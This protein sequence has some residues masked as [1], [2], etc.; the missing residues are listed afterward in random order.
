MTERADVGDTMPDIALETPDGGTVR[1]SDFRGRKLVVFFYPKDDTPGCTTQACSLRDGWEGIREKAL[2]FGV[3]ID[4]VKSHNKFITKHSLP[5]PL[6][7]DEEKAIVRAY[8]V[9]VEKSMYGK[10]FMGTERSTF[11][12]GPDGEIEAILEKVAPAEHLNL[13]AAALAGK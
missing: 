8:G 3:S 10:T 2:V 6:I 12:I 9:W 5:Y 7:A 1:P 11:V 4:P 13:L